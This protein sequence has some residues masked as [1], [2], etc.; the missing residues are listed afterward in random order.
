MHEVHGEDGHVRL[1]FN[2]Q[3][4]SVL[5]VAGA[6]IAVAFYIYCIID[7]LRTRSGDTRAL[8]KFVWLILVILVPLLGGVLWLAFGRVWNAPGSPWRR[9]RGPV[10]PD[11]DPAFLKKIADDA[12]SSRMRQR[13]NK[14]DPTP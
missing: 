8:P 10:A 3:E 13:R 11:D 6:I 4:V 12:W 9:R 14:P 2:T 1:C 7:V 5:R